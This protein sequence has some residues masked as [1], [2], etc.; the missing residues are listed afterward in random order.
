M[1]ALLAKA[2]FALDS[3]DPEAALAALGPALEKHARDAP[4]HYCLSQAHARLGHVDLAQEHER[5]YE[6]LQQ[7]AQQLAELKRRAI[8]QPAEPAICYQ[9]GLLNERLG[10][11][12]AAESWYV[13][14]L[15]LDASHAGAQARLR[16]MA[17]KPDAGDDES[18]PTSR[19]RE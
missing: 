18:G 15:A 14:A 3:N 1:K 19:G 6:E 7:L 9:L 12:D 11:P 10:V 4:L 5:K 17:P 2:R 8:E 13:A 16:A